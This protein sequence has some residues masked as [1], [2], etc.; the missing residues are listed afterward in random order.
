MM[1]RMGWTSGSG[2]GS[3]LQG[4]TGPV[5]AL[6]NETRV[7]L[8]FSSTTTTTTSSATTIPKLKFN[9]KLSKCTKDDQTRAL[10]RLLRP[11][12]ELQGVIKKRKIQ[13]ND[14]DDDENQQQRRWYV[15]KPRQEQ[16]LWS[17][18][19]TRVVM[20]VSKKDELENKV[21]EMDPSQ[22]VTR[23][24]CLSMLSSK[25]LDDVK[26]LNKMIS[27]TPSSSSHITHFVRSLPSIRE[28]FQHRIE[29]LVRE[30]EF[31]HL[32]IEIM[33]DLVWCR[34]AVSSRCLDF[35]LSCTIE[36]KDEELRNEI[37][38]CLT[39]NTFQ[40][41]T[42][43]IENFAVENLKKNGW[44]LYAALCMKRPELISSSS[45]SSD[46]DR[47]LS[48]LF[49]SIESE[50]EREAF[51]KDLRNRMF[52]EGVTEEILRLMRAEKE[53]EKGDE[54]EEE[55]KDEE[56]KKSSAGSR[57]IE[58]M[59]S[60][61]TI[62]TKIEE[63]ILI[64][65]VEALC[66]ENKSEK[67][68]P[69]D[70]WRETVVH[71]YEKTSNESFLVALAPLLSAEGLEK[72]ISTMLNFV[73]KDKK[74]KKRT[75]SIKSFLSHVSGG[76]K[77]AV[78]LVCSLIRVDVDSKEKELFKTVCDTLKLCLKQF[79]PHIVGN[80]LR[81]VIHNTK[82]ELPLLLLRTILMF[83]K[84][85]SNLKLQIVEM[86][87]R[88]VDRQV[89]T[90]PRLWEGFKIL[91]RI[92][93]PETCSVCVNLPFD[94]LELLETDDSQRDVLMEHLRNYVNSKQGS[95][96]TFSPDLLGWLGIDIAT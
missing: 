12:F 33:R 66:S 46:Q 81:R 20:N 6:G 75:S 41:Y 13:D 71:L 77:G 93:L 27:T 76:S 56:K 63:R 14:D 29:E 74:K 8:G 7:G 16:S 45:S 38:T 85:H 73:V 88:L 79:E 3:H 42:G 32:G 91:L 51:L 61:I 78:D 19:V 90:R 23:N 28:E 24:L 82:R 39:E 64:C 43:R 37:I 68:E 60:P 40:M 89:W 30:K 18:L 95:G 52:F 59:L 54:E 22:R 25:L 67:L 9:N 58:L 11:V 21:L 26:I 35:M 65:A 70:S 96:E 86:L 50:E 69:I 53:E 34:P 48:N 57:L 55:K 62:P 44:P 10:N 15:S 4:R 31:R 83:F 36:E 87:R 5:E 92:L 17:S 80:A 72:Y 47:L 2:L 84:R 49:G 1:E 94:R